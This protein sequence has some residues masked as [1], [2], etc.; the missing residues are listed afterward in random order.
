[1]WTTFVGIMLILSAIDVIC[2]QAYSLLDALPYLTPSIIAILTLITTTLCRQNA[3]SK[4]WLNGFFVSTATGAISGLFALAK[5]PE[6][7]AAKAIGV[8]SGSTGFTVTMLLLYLLAKNREN[9][10]QE[11]EDD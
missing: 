4:F 10:E 9:L 8:F 3:T 11:L 2:H 1:M 5:Y 6:P 7:I